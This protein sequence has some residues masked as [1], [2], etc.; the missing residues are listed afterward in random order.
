MWV[1]RQFEFAVH[2]SYEKFELLFEWAALRELCF[3][4]VVIDKDACCQKKA[5]K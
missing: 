2:G 3:D 1:S 4:S 5:N